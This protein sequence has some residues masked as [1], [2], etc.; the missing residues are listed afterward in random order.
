[1][2]EVLSA[3]QIEFYRENG[4]LVLERQISDDVIEACHGAIAE[5]RA[6]AV[7]LT[8]S[9]DR[10]DIEDSH[11]PDDPR[12]RRIKLPHQNH[13]VF[14]ELMRSDAI[15][16]PARDLLGPDIRLHTSKLNM[17]SAGY[18][19]AVKWH[20]DWAFYPHTNDDLLAVGVLLDDAGPDN[21]PLLMIPG[22]HRG[23][24]FDHHDGGVFAGAM[25]L[26]AAGI[27]PAG[28]VALTGPRG[29]ITL[30]HVRI[31]HGSAVNKS[32]RDRQLLLYEMSAADAFPVMGSTTKMGTLDEYNSRMLCGEPT[33]MPRLADVPVR[34]PLPPPDQAGSI[35]QVQG[36]SA[37]SD[38][39]AM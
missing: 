12:I 1:M 2:A 32:D 4:Y 24:V 39:A 29:S 35:Y 11:R 10:I 9:T 14:D 5:F 36:Q 33:I 28:A 37:T 8:Q 34:M 27:D 21:G 26:A 30:H 25:D 20:Q 16:A 3:A 7:G 31:V 6:E 22:S 15:L 19:A 17:K 38:P 13:R 23:P 18:G